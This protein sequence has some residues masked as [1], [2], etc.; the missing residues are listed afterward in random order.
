MEDRALVGTDYYLRML[1]G[2]RAVLRTPP[3]DDPRAEPL[4]TSN[5]KVLPLHLLGAARSSRT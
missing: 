4:S 5:G 1:G 3:P 2:L